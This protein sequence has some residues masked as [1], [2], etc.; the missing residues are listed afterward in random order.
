MMEKTCLLDLEI[1][2][3]DLEKIEW[4][5]RN[6]WPVGEKKAGRWVERMICLVVERIVLTAFLE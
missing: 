1:H 3:L 6:I 2:L 5:K 4:E